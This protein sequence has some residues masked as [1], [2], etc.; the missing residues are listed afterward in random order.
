MNV[1]F[2]KI[3]QNLML[4]YVNNKRMIIYRVIKNYFKLTN[5]IKTKNHKTLEKVKIFKKHLII[6][7]NGKTIIKVMIKCQ[8]LLSQNNL[9]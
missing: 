3:T 2:L 6:Y 1:C 4:I 8:I 7:L 9:I 5:K